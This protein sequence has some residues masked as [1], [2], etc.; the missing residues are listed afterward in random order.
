MV[1][2]DKGPCSGCIFYFSL[3]TPPNPS[4]VYHR[5]ME[6]KRVQ[7]RQLSRPIEP[8]PSQIRRR[9]AFPRFCPRRPFVGAGVSYSPQERHLPLISSLFQH[10]QLLLL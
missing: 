8:G 10:Q 7:P 3:V 4:N 2:M 9:T 5:Q 1:F 6:D